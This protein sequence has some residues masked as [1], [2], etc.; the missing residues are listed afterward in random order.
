MKQKSESKNFGF[1]LAEG[2][3]HVDLLQTKVRFGFTLA[4][5]LITLG[6]IGVVAAMTIPTLIK[7]TQDKQFRVKFKE[8]ISIISQAMKTVYADSEETYTATDWIQM[9]VYFCKLQKNLKVLNS[10]IDCSQVAEDS[11]YK[12]N[13]EWPKT[14]KTSWHKD[15]KWYDKKGNPQFANDEYS[16][17]T[18]DLINGMRINF[19]CYN[20]IWVDVNGAQGPNTIGRDIFMMYFEKDATNPR[21]NLKTGTTVTAN[22]CAVGKGNSTPKLNLDNYMEDCLH[23]S[24]WGCSFMFN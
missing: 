9:P 21:V 2:A 6:I 13:A 17:L 11:V 3:T 22:G 7:N 10:G 5:V 8:S 12:S 23:G 24:G 4:E 15:K 16:S 1:I 18:M 14:N 19:N 20:W